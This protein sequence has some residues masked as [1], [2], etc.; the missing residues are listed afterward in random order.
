M[1]L[2]KCGVCGKL[3]FYPVRARMC[4]YCGSP[5]VVGWH[6]ELTQWVKFLRHRYISL[7]RYG[8]L[9]NGQLGEIRHGRICRKW[10]KYKAC[11][12]KK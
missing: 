5:L 12:P 10:R 1:K 7:P 4:I 6:G 9:A 3:D 8:R 11:L 2:S